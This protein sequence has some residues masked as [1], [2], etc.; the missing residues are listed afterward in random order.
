MPRPRPR[1]DEQFPAW[2]D[3]A[4]GTGVDPGGPLLL[5]LSGGADSVF[6]LRT[7]CAARVRPALHALHVDHGLRG[8]ESAADAAFC[9]ALARE[10]GVPFSCVRLELD[11][12]ASDLERR[13]REARYRA[14]ARHARELDVELVLTAHH[15]DDA[16][17]TL[18]MRWLRGT[19]LPGLAGLRALGPLPVPDA[20]GAN[21]RVARPLLPY[22][23]AEIREGLLR[24]AQPWCEDNSNTSARFTRNRVRHQLLPLLEAAAGPGVREDLRAFHDAAAGMGD[25]L[26]PDAAR[27][28][29]GSAAP[30]D[31]DLISRRSLSALPTPL[32]H[33]L[34]WRSIVARTGRAPGAAALKRT[35]R[36]LRSGVSGQWTLRGAWT[37][38]LSKTHL[39][40][41]PPGTFT[42]ATPRR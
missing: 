11:G 14:L 35:T 3:L 2:E 25:L 22:S 23:A 18:L 4:I 33:Q 10:H 1:T 26:S 28:R 9:Q 36:A 38:R 6:L 13:A 15:A 21:L 16:L 12:A 8:T 5:A 31:R 32:L 19:T 29:P 24:A 20:G 30:L 40:L 37:L 41:L 39:E 42:G 17:E 27:D 7:L 34:L